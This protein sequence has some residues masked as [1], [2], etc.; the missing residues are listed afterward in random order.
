MACSCRDVRLPQVPREYFMSAGD[1]TERK[2]TCLCPCACPPVAG[3]PMTEAERMR[4]LKAKIVGN[5]C[6]FNQQTVCAVGITRAYPVGW[7]SR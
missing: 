7:V 1:S 4:M 5:C 2:K 3:K 6:E